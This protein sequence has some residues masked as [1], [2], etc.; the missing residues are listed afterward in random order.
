MI[1]KEEIKDLA[2]K[3]P[4]EVNLSKRGIKAWDEIIDIMKENEEKIRKIIESKEDIDLDRF[5]HLLEKGNRSEEEKAYDQIRRALWRR[6]YNY[7]RDLSEYERNIRKIENNK[8]IKD[9]FKDLLEYEG[10]TSMYFFEELDHR[11]MSHFI[12]YFLPSETRQKGQKEYNAI[13]LREDKE[14]PEETYIHFAN[15]EFAKKIKQYIENL[16]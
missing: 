11:D 2:K 10:K 1:S 13:E 7:E 8:H 4:K 16:E 3:F 6:Y 9:F 12:K 15:N 14:N 5:F